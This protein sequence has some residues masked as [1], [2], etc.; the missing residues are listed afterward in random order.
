MS[1]LS[2]DGKLIATFGETRRKPVAVADIPDQVKQA[3]IA[4]EDARFYDHPGSTGAVFYARFGCL[5]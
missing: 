2:A 1:V 3:V 5:R 4:I